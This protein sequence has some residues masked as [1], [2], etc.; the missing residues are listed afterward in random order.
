MKLIMNEIYFL[1]YNSLEHQYKIMYINS[2]CLD[3][4]KILFLIRE[5]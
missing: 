5:M 2:S 1:I 3:M 4:N